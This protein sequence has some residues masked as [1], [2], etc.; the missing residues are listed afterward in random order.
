MK[1]KVKA[2]AQSEPSM[3]GIPNRFYRGRIVER[4][5]ANRC[6]IRLDHLGGEIH[7]GFTTKHEPWFRKLL[8]D[9]ERDGLIRI[10]GNG[11]LKTRRA[12]LA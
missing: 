9:L 3:D 2:R 1:R 5:R 12:S 11:S 6:G 10:S 4:L 7:A 8:A